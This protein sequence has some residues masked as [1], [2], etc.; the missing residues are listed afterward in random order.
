M[1]GVG[2]GRLDDPPPQKRKQRCKHRWGKENSTD[3]TT[4]VLKLGGWTWQ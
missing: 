4:I 2:I 3:T 1:P